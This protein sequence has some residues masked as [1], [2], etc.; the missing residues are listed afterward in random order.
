MSKI[1]L[2]S[3]NVLH[4]NLM[5]SLETYQFIIE[6]SL[7]NKNKLLTSYPQNIYFLL[8]D[9]NVIV[10]AIGFLV[11]LF[12]V[13]FGQGMMIILK[14]LPKMNKNNKV[15]KLLFF[16][17]ICIYPFTRGFCYQFHFWY[18]IM[19]IDIAVAFHYICNSISKYKIEK[20]VPKSN[21]I[22]YYHGSIRSNN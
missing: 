5:K 7:N 1:I 2:I 8:P 11:L 9:F 22:R 14:D 16:F 4:E 13:S 6:T 17:K 20:W 12:S 18:I 10:F 19:F 15:Q 21:C 3:F